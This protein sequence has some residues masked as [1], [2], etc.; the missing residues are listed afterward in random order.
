MEKKKSK[1]EEEEERGANPIYGTMG[2]FEAE[3]NEGFGV[4]VSVPLPCPDSQPDY[5]LRHAQDSHIYRVCV[6]VCA[7]QRLQLSFRSLSMTFRRM[8]GGDF[9]FVSAPRK[10]I[11]SQGVAH[12]RFLRFFLFLVF[13][14]YLNQFR[15]IYLT[16]LV[17]K[18]ERA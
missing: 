3:G 4:S 11:V 9:V 6:C 2:S 18:L 5:P 1:K 17:L 12:H 15:V 13:A 16:I 10:A 14:R 7:Y 8:K